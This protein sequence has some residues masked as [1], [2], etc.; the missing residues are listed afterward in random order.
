MVT[1]VYD[2]GGVCC[3]DY[4]NDNDETM[5]VHDVD[6]GCGDNDPVVCEYKRLVNNLLTM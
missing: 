2:D 6:G 3:G 1:H 5:K 4:D